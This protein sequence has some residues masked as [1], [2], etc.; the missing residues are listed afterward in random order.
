LLSTS[1]IFFEFVV[2]IF[3]VNCFRMCHHIISKHNVDLPFLE[4][5][6]K[7]HLFQRTNQPFQFIYRT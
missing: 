3:V 6:K 1:L 4:T 5:P 7:T 2:K